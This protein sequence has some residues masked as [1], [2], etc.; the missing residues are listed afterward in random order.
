MMNPHEIIRA[1]YRPGT[2]GYDIFMDHAR[3]VTKKSIEV[4]QRVSH[5]QPDI[6]FIEEAAM[7]HDIGIFLTHAPAIHCR[8]RRPY[9]CHGFLGRELLDQ[10]GFPRHGLV[11]E[12]HTGAGI[13][14]KNISDANLPL[15][16]RE[17]V[18][19]SLEEQIICVA[20]KFYSKSPEKADREETV[21]TISASLS[22]ISPSHGQRFLKWAKTFNL[23]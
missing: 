16:H 10:W 21:D 7:L 8:G 20:D 17:M 23:T 11:A 19:L 3:R 6:A 4:A 9:I 18:P 5:L 2:A 12:R 15:P 1:Y 14:L 13:T 22:T